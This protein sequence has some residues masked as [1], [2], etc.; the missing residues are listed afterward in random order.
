M[1]LGSL[2]PTHS[3]SARKSASSSGRSAALSPRRLAF[4]LALLS[5]AGLRLALGEDLAV[6]ASVEAKL[7]GKVAS[8][9]RAFAPRIAGKV[10]IAIVAQPSDADSARAAAQMQAAF[11]D[12]GTIAG[13]PHE[14]I[15]LR[16][17]D[18]HTLATT[19]AQRKVAIVYLTPGLDGQIEGISKALNDSGVIS[20][21]GVLS[22][23]SKGAVLGFELVS[24]RPKLVINL[25][26]AKRQGMSFQAALLDLARVIK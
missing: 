14:E 23:V 6:P 4:E 9:D 15:L 16:W 19:C 20:V 3:S 17:S 5:T 11:R 22:Y 18:A 7:T 25:S 12:V 13:F 2:R 26:S 8:Y 10:V 24:G 21:A 1:L